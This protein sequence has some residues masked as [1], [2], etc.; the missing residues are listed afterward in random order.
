MLEQVGG[1]AEVRVAP[2]R[3]GGS[4]THLTHLLAFLPPDTQAWQFAENFRYLRCII[5]DFDVEL[6]A[7]RQ[8]ADV[9]TRFAPRWMFSDARLWS[10]ASL[11]ADECGEPQA[12]NPTYRDSL[13][14]V[15]FQ[16]LFRGAPARH[17]ERTPSGLAPRQL[18]RVTE[19]MEQSNTVPLKE[20]ALMSGLSVSHFG[21]AF[22][23][24]T[25][26]SPHRWL[27]HARVRR[28]QQV[29]LEADA[30]LAEVALASGFADQSHLT[31]VFR[32]LTGEAP[33]AWR[34]KR[35]Q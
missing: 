35:R 31:R 7:Q 8:E 25:G 18:Q 21:R 19:R 5:L 22:K 30:R 13:A 1:R 12:I 34:R 14:L 27:L 3:P 24:S 33:G 9:H 11:I 10:L 26:M 28:A 4:R 29:L 16:Y 23:A 6:L 20:L 2:D 17:G 32:S 15:M